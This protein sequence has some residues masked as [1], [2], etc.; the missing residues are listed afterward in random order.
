LIFFATYIIKDYISQYYQGGKMDNKNKKYENVLSDEKI[1]ELYWNRDEKAIRETDK[2]YGSYLYSIA[3]NIVNDRLDTEECVNDTYLGTWERIPPARPNVFHLFLAR[4]IRNIA[5]S[6][7]R[8]TNAQKRI[9]S[10]MQVSLDE[11]DEC[12]AASPSAEEDY[13]VENVAAILN[14]YLRSLSRRKELIFVC[15]YYYA[16]KIINIAKM[17]GVS[18]NTVYRELGSIREG[19]K[20]ALEKEGY[21]LER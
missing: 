11:L 1:I 19:L 5:I 12:I 4:I 6:K 9:S 14:E 2:K 21:Y 17:L 8:K 10:E 3:F 15:R 20:K 7:F 16:D 18:V 13:Y